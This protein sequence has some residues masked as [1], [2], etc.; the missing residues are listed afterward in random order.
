MRSL[1]ALGAWTLWDFTLPGMVL[2]ASHFPQEVQRGQ[3]K[4]RDAYILLDSLEG[5]PMAL[6]CHHVE[7]SAG[8]L[9]S[10]PTLSTT[11]GQGSLSL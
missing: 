11:E 6:P 7:T 1:K 9:C 2:A 4:V 3:D 10:A 5:N 8:V